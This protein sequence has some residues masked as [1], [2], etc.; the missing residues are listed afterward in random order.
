MRQSERARGVLV[1]VRILAGAAAVAFGATAMLAVLDA[2][3]RFL[4][5]HGFLQNLGLAFGA[6][7]L[8][9]L[10]ELLSGTRA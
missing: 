9:F 8:G 7:A 1:G 5:L 4:P 2:G 3:G 6:L 10:A